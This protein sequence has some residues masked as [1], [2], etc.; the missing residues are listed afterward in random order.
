[1]ARMG[2]T[3][4]LG[5]D[6]INSLCEGLRFNTKFNVVFRDRKFGRKCCIIFVLNEPVSDLLHCQIGQEGAVH[7]QTEQRDLVGRVIDW[8]NS[9]INCISKN[10]ANTSI[11]ITRIFIIN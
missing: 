5:E 6:M 8:L 3:F 7:C 11:V 1:M 10:F 2:N 9:S 4:L